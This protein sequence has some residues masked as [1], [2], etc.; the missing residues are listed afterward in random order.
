[1]RK[2]PRIHYG[3]GGFVTTDVVVDAADAGPILN[4][5]IDELNRSL[6]RADGWGDEGSG[7]VNII[8]ERAA[9]SRD[10]TPAAAT[11]RM[12]EIRRGTSARTSECWF[13]AF[14]MGADHSL[15]EYED[16]VPRFPAGYEAAHEMVACRYEDEMGQLDRKRL[17]HSLTNFSKGYFNAE[18]CFDVMEQAVAEPQDELVAA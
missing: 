11:R 13:E 17:A 15:R 5:L 2:P 6:A 4:D 3:N 8:A 9:Q 1:M 16:Q 10:T 12:Y 14:V 7:A 18:R